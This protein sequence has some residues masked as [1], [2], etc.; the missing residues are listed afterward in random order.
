M[1]KI[2]KESEVRGE[3]KKKNV[4]MSFYYDSSNLSETRTH[5]PTCSPDAAV[6]TAHSGV[7]AGG[8]HTHVVQGGLAHHVVGTPEPG[9][10][11]S[12]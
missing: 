2:L 5:I 11:L 6:L 1:L 8:V 10:S 3:K 7:L 4:K 9:S 12:L